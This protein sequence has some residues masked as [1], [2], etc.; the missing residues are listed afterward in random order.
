MQFTCSLHKRTFNSRFLQFK[1][2][3]DVAVSACYFSSSKSNL[4]PFHN[5]AFI[6]KSTLNLTPP[7]PT[8]NAQYTVPRNNKF[9]IPQT[10]Y[11][12]HLNTVV[13]RRRRIKQHIKHI[14]AR[15]CDPKP[16]PPSTKQPLSHVST[17]QFATPIKAQN[18]GS[19]CQSAPGR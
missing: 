9:L 17:V 1:F 3:V 14:H 12:C 2:A 13:E 7:G 11:P 15:Q 6:D 18:H 16:Q 19:K 4:S 10:T 5:A 8:S